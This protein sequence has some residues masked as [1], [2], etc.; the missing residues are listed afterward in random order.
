MEK[1]DIIEGLIELI[2]DDENILTM[3]MA[4]KSNIDIESAKIIS[5]R[6][7]ELTGDVIHSNLADI[8]KMTFMSGEARKHF[9]KVDKSTVKAVAI[10]ANTSFQTPL[11]NLYL[12]FSRPS[13]PTKIFDSEAEAR[14]WLKK[15]LQ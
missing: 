1:R 13:I 11:I 5:E 2:L 7:G 9:G 14:T 6:V 12:K 10:V 3:R 8:S 4:E 15:S